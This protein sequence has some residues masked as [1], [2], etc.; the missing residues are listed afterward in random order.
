MIPDPQGDA[1]DW[2][3][4]GGLLAY[5]TETVWGLGADA[6]SDAG[7]VRLLRW[8]GRAEGAPV[9]VLVESLTDV[10]TLDIEP[11]VEA[12]RL[13]AAFWPG[14]LTPVMASRRRFA[15][16]LARSDGA[17]GVRCSAHPLAAAIARRLREEGVG[18]ITATSLN[19]SGARA[20][21]TRADAVKLCGQGA[22]EPRLV[23]V[24]GAEA[25]G[26]EESTVLDRTGPAPR[27]RRG[28]ALP[29]EELQPLLGQ[30]GAA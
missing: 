18:P 7:L 2:L 14:P 25:G 24:E 12:E 23:D 11:T 20:A 26:D 10:E 29:A 4:R 9:A 3:R 8:K 15:P 6:V 1:A 27:V 21:R 17:L 30:V 28:G 16:G 13:A 19:A 22:D 5:P